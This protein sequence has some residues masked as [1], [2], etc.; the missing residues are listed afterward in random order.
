MTNSVAGIGLRTVQPCNVAA[1]GT[2][3][4]VTQDSMDDGE[5]I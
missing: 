2:K 3:I 5:E 1:G 4:V